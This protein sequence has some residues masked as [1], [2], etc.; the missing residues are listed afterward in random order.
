MIVRNFLDTPKQ[1]QS[2]HA[3]KGQGK[4]ALV[5]DAADFETALRFIRYVEL[6]PG[7]SIGNHRHGAN[8][9]V[10]VILSGSGMM[11]VNGSSQ[12]VRTGDVILNK[13]SW[14]H[15]LE[16]TSPASLNLLVFEVEKK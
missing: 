12:A 15:G 2:I 10:F 3:G 5:F 13:P 11:T 14:E 4:N 1:V 8:E 7:A 9:E 16:N 6:K